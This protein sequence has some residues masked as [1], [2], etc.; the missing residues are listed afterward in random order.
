MRVR[1]IL[2][3]FAATGLAITGTTLG[4]SGSA[5]ANEGHGDHCDDGYNLVVGSRYADVLP[6]SDCDDV[7]LAFAGNDRVVAKDGDDIVRGGRGDDV[8][9]AGE[10]DDFIR[11]GTGYD[12]CVGDVDDQFVNCEEVLI[13]E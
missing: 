5:S 12:R 8:L 6:G 2:I 4:T 11:G 10:G 13:T 1:N 3:G 9:F 7:I